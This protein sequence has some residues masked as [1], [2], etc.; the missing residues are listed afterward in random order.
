MEEFQITQQQKKEKTELV[1]ANIYNLPPIPKV[2][3]DV[4]RLLDSQTTSMTVLNSAISKDHS[5]VTKILSIANS[6]LYGLQRKVSTIDFAI[7]ILGFS[8]LRNIVSVL[9]LIESFKNKSDKYLDH[10]DFW[11][12]SFLIG[13]AA[14]KIAED[15]GFNNSGEAFIA[16]FLHEIGV[17]I[18]HRFFHSSFIT[19]TNKVNY[20]NMSFRDAELLTLGMTHEEIGA[21]MLEKWNFPLILADAVRYHHN[22]A[23]S[24]S[25]RSL[26]SLVHL[27]DFMTQEL[28][29]GNFKWD[30]GLRLNKAAVSVLGFNGPD[31]VIKFVEKYKELFIH[32]KL[33]VRYLN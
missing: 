7:L 24:L 32:Q 16:G 22:P 12:H 30:N 1:L 14:K 13:N 31:G 25:G 17:S 15:L 5:L 3:S 28:M 9:A 4:L 23:G 26:A 29:I 19:I 11:L 2:I 20:E 6:P 21:Y 18:I 10:R 27:A 8:E 33:A